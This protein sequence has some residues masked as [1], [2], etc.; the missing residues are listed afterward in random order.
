MS[1]SRA[2][3]LRNVK[4]YLI[5]EL[6]LSDEESESFLF[7]IKNGKSNLQKI[8]NS[9]KFSNKI[10]LDTL[11]SLVE[12]GM[13]INISTSEYESLHPKFAVVNRYRRLCQDYNLPFKKNLLI[14]SLGTILQRP[15]E[16]ARTK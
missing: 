15:F 8:A 10:V 5:S 11:E 13:I 1:A 4:K 6:K 16:D 9:S 3:N 12:K 2:I 14:D 7:I